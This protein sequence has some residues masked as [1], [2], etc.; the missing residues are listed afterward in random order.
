MI[1]CG[2]GV[3]P[4][5]HGSA[6]DSSAG[7]AHA[8]GDAGPV[9]VYV[10]HMVDADTPGRLSG[11]QL[12][13][14]TGRLQPVPGSPYDLPG[15]GEPHQVAVDPS[16][17]FVYVTT[18]KATATN[19]GQIYVFSRDAQTGALSPIVGSPFSAALDLRSPV[20]DP[21]GRF[22]YV[23]EPAA[24]MVYAFQLNSTTGAVQPL[25]DRNYFS[26]ANNLDGVAMAPSKPFL[27]ATA[28]LY[29]SDADPDRGFV[30]TY[31]I[32]G[33]GAL[34]RVGDMTPAGRDTGIPAV[35]PNGRFLYAPNSESNDVSGYA[36]D[37]AT[38]APT[39]LIGSPFSAGAGTVALALSPS[40]SHL[41]AVNGGESSVSA[42]SIDAATGALH[43]VGP[44]VDAQ[45]TTLGCIAVEPS[46]RFAFIA[47]NGSATLDAYAIDPN[48][49]E[50]Q[51]LEPMATPPKPRSVATTH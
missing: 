46:G 22:L 36:L 37:P 33:N 4:S 42:F 24:E 20:I 13:P 15:G 31:A 1:G 27:Y 19:R 41:Y 45:G 28:A 29:V 23:G 14:N 16:N 5:G 32:A 25:P 44:A 11:Y 17:R 7:S 50:L 12:A 18:K 48:S 49:G 39:P 38:G 10:T 26:A 9:T 3:A 40:G 6:A 34:T 43:P 35:H 21:Q 47:G 30:L 8:A 51:R 2:G